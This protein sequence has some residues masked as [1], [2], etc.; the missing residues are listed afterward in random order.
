MQLVTQPIRGT[1]EFFEEHFFRPTQLPSHQEL[2][3]IQ[4][5]PAETG[6]IRPHGISQDKGIASIILSTR[7]T[8][9]VTE[10]IQLLG[11]HRKDVQPSLNQPFHNG[12]TWDFDSD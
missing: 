2:R 9:A 10:P 4:P 12:A 6:L 5:E 7:D 8:M 1:T 11:M 3:L